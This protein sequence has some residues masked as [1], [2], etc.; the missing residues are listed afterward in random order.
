M[1]LHTTDLSRAARFC[2]SRK[3]RSLSNACFNMAHQIASI[4]VAMVITVLS[5]IIVEEQNEMWQGQA[6]TQ[7]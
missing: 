1:H 6:V 7:L 4:F 3:V 5:K 2:S